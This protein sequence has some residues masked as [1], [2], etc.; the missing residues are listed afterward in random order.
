MV[1]IS[2]RIERIHILG[3]RALIT[4]AVRPD[5]TRDNFC[6]NIDIERCYL[7]S[8]RNASMA[9]LHSTLSTPS[10]NIVLL[11]EWHEKCRK[12]E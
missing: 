9:S 1:H 5:V 6:F 2:K 7:K 12:S 3:T 10:H 8:T 4:T 11:E